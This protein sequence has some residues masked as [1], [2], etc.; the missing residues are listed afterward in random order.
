MCVHVHHRERWNCVHTRKMEPRTRC[1]RQKCSCIHI[2]AEK[3][4]ESECSAV[5]VT[6]H[7]LKVLWQSDDQLCVRRAHLENAATVCLRTNVHVTLSS[8]SGF[9]FVCKFTCYLCVRPARSQSW[10]SLHDHGFFML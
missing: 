1:P 6:R 4:H 7:M 10:Q 2:A 5:L 9:L 3:N 8:M